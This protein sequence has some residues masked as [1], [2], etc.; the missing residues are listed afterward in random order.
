[1]SL[2]LLL[3]CSA[4]GQERIALTGATVWTGNSPAMRGA[5]VLI[6]GDRIVAV[7]MDLKIPAGATLVDLK[8]SNVYPGLIDAGAE[9]WLGEAPAPKIPRAD[10]SAVDAA[11]ILKRAG[12]DVNSWI[13]SG[14]LTFHLLPTHGILR[15]KSVA[16]SVAGGDWRVVKRHVSMVTNPQG[17]GYRNRVRRNPE[18]RGPFP[19]RSIG[20][21][22]F[23]RQSLLEAPANG[24][25][26]LLVPAYEETDMRRVLY[27]AQEQGGRFALLGGHEPAG[28]AVELR[29]AGIP[30]IVDLDHPGALKD[31]HPEYRE[32]KRAVHLRD[33]APLAASSL[34]KAGVPLAFASRGLKEGGSFLAAMRLAVRAGLP[35]D[36]ALK[37]ATASAAAILG[38]SHEIGSIA[39]GRLANLIVSDGDL[40]ADKTRIVKAM[41]NGKWLPFTPRPPV[42]AISWKAPQPQLAPVPKS[43]TIVIRNTTVFRVSGET[44]LN[45]SVLIRDGKIAAIGQVAIP[46]GARVI[47]GTGKWL[48]PGIIDCHSHIATDSHNEPSEW[49]TSM[50]RIRDTL[51]PLDVPMA[52]VLAAGVTAANTLHGSVNGIGGQTEVIKFRYGAK[53]ADMIIADAPK[54]IKFAVKKAVEIGLD[55]TEKL[56]R[57]TLDEAREYAQQWDAF[58]SGQSSLRPRKDLR[59]EPLVEVLRGQR[60]VNVHI[61]DVDEMR[62]IMRIA[63]DFGFRVRILQHA[64]EAYKIPGEILEHGAGVSIFSELVGANVYNSAILTKRGIL[65]SI[66]SDGE[67]LARNMP[68]Q[69]ALSLRH[70]DLTPQQAMALITLNPARQLR[71]DHRTGSI[72]VGKDA[73]LVLYSGDPLRTYSFAETVLIDGK[74]YHHRPLPKNDAPVIAW[75]KDASLPPVAASEVYLIRNAR[76]FPVSGPMLPRASILIRDRRIVEVAASIA[77]PPGARVID[78]E[79]LNVYPGL[80]DAKANMRQ[81]KFDPRD[82]EFSRMRN[83]GI[84]HA[85]MS[86]GPAADP[87]AAFV[88]LSAKMTPGAPVGY[89]PFPTVSRIDASYDERYYELPWSTLQKTFRAGMTRLEAKYTSP[90]NELTLLYGENNVDVR[91][92]V[93]FAKKHG[94]NNY[95]VCGGAD[96]RREAANLKTSGARVVLPSVQLMPEN[97]D[98][99]ADIVYKTPA[100]LHRM[101]VPFALSTETGVQAGFVVPHHLRLQAGYSVAYGLPYQAALRA[102]TLTP[103]EFLGRAKDL[104]SIEPGKLAD[105]VITNGD[106]FDVKTR[107][108]AIFVEGNPTDSS[109]AVEREWK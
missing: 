34:D 59:L 23:L 108:L 9:R 46:A 3:L 80:I 82:E 61:Y 52:R 77:A 98:E 95:L 64:T 91:N 51:N 60:D 68:H 28:V 2:L 37:A 58:R 44:L 69:A 99:P 93:H 96:L 92:A 106:L 88:S 45:A 90:S 94:L 20:V 104:G 22:A 8:G 17:L 109:M 79:G 15:G 5:T 63:K 18:R 27:L 83:H 71:I 14:V 55:G 19:M 73:D 30:V 43:E 49:V 4:F 107:V 24:E 42:G 89:V 35:P 31:V 100:L 29:D 87:K 75:K 38:I 1:M 48:A 11:V 56:I 62:L 10:D 105:V 54:G 53:A 26:P 57:K 74:V 7:G 81:V 21:F 101:G 86:T 84:T 33:I 6:E 47:D 102:V 66:N 76:V 78:A 103:A 72:D 65:A 25:L 36:Q 32:S 16:V 70:G 41:A 97:D 67:A 13:E 12:A 50:V 40:F 39:P 85:V